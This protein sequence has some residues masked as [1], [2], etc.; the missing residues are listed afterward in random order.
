MQIGRYD[1]DPLAIV[2]TQKISD[3]EY[4]VSLPHGVKATLNAEEKAQVDKAIELHRAT[5]Y[6]YGIAQAAGLRG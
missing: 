3:D 2:M 4:E 5:A 6:V 1:F